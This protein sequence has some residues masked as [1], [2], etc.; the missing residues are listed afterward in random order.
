MKHPK[1]WDLPK[2]H[3]D[4]GETNFECA[5]RE[6]QEETGI[7]EHHLSIEDGFKF[8]DRYIVESKKG[9]KKKKLIIYLAE[10]IEDVE[11]VPTEHEGYEWVDWNPPHAIQ[12]KTIDPLLAEVE[13]WWQE[14]QKVA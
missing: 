12:K 6:L 2:G 5:L 13:Q 11:I 8:K 1:R 7:E 10:L 9:K 14:Q 3:V 4:D